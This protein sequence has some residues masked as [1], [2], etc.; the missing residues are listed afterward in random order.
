MDQAAIDTGF[1]FAIRHEAHA[2]P[3]LS[4]FLGG[5]L[6]SILRTP[7][8]DPLGRGFSLVARFD[9]ASGLIRPVPSAEYWPN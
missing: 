1:D 4:E 5:W 6:T 2:A 7:P 9:L 8:V 3:G